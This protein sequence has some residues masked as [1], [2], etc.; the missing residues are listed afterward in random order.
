MDLYKLGVLVTLPIVTMTTTHNAL[1]QVIDIVELYNEK[2]GLHKTFE[3]SDYSLD[4]LLEKI[5]KTLIT[6]SFI[7]RY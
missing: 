7:S 1:G 5:V 3:V 4:E 2:D 6:L